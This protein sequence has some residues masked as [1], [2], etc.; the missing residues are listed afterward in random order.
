M[1]ECPNCKK[2]IKDSAKFCPWCRY[3]LISQNDN[4]V[5]SKEIN[6]NVKV[7]FS[8]FFVIIFSFLFIIIFVILINTKNK[9]K[10]QYDN[11]SFYKGNIN[12]NNYKNN[13]DRWGIITPSY[14]ICS[15]AYYTEKEAKKRANKLKK[16]GY[17]SGYLWIPDYPSLSGAKMYVV[18]I[19]PFKNRSIC[20]NELRKY[21][22][23]NKKAYAVLV[24]QNPKRVEIR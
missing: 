17:R 20:I 3:Q 9:T 21:Q 8:L 23:I 18:F 6:E 11:N 1:I 22:R 24:S 4:Q 16:A 12:L 19:G 13:K 5:E 15:S 7:G 2:R 10:N 14:I